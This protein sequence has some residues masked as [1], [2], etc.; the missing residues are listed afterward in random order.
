MGKLGIRSAH[1][2][3]PDG[4]PFQLPGDDEAP[5]PL[6]I[7][8]D[9]KDVV[10]HLALPL[11][12]LSG[13]EVTFGEGTQ[14][15]ARYLSDVTE[16]ADSNDVGAQ[17]AEVQLGRL[18]LSLRPAHELTEG[19][20]SLPVAHVVERQASGGVLLEPGFIP[21]VVNNGPSSVLN[22]FCKEIHGLLRQRGEVLAQRM[23]QP[24]RGGI[25]EVGDFLLLQLIN[26][27]TGAAQ[28]WVRTGSIH[29][30]RL[31]EEL[32]RLAAE[33]TTFD[34]ERRRPRC[35]PPTTMTT[36]GAAFRH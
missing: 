4:T 33:L 9:L 26:H 5:T 11:R 27:W 30:E 35:C 14:S 7:G 12:R 28:H 29:P 21:T 36:S 31:F 34:H 22:T 23:I 16:V 20:V 13:S 2:V 1:G 6:D 15:P 3:L 19:W 17:P 18:R 24:E 32:L 8:K 25:G 10:V